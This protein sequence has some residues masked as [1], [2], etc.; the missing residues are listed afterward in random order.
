MERDNP[1]FPK[2]RDFYT[3]RCKYCGFECRKQQIKGSSVPLTRIG[4]YG[5][6]GTPKPESFADE[7][8]TASTISFVAASG[9]DPAYLSDSAYLFADKLFR[10]GMTIRISTDSGTNDGDKTIA[11]RGVSRGKI[12]LSSS[13][14]LTDESAATAGAVTISEVAYQP[15]TSPSGCPLCGSR[16]SL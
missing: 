5:S 8:Y 10:H 4:N 11:D 16:N 7:M 9:D 13:D 3:Y 12:L 14:S 6:E 1:L 15:N 2:D